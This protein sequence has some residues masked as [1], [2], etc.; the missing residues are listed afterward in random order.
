MGSIGSVCGTSSPEETERTWLLLPKAP[1]L[2]DQ[3]DKDDE[4]DEDDFD[5]D[6]DDDFE[7]ELD[8]ELERELAEKFADDGFGGEDKDANENEAG[9]TENEDSGDE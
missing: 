5:D 9:C 8:Q 2:L 3:N 4:W 6:F 1:Q 7:A